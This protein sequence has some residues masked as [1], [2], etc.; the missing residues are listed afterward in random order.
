MYIYIIAFFMSSFLL[1]L[2]PRFNKNK[3]L[4]LFINLIALIIP[5]IL[6]GVRN[7]II[8]TDVKSYVIPMF[9][10]AT[11]SKN[12]YM[13]MNMKWFSIWT[14]WEIKQIEFGFS[15]L[16]YIVCKLTGNLQWLLFCIQLLTIIPIYLGLKKF[17]DLKSDI[18]FAILVY[19]LLFY[20]LSL[21]LMR[22]F[23]SIGI[24]FFGT[25]CLINDRNGKMKFWLALFVFKG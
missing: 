23:I 17:K 12:F 3:I 6:A 11:N 5:C 1:K 20:N 7:S 22:Q 14:Y 21:N 19:F 9:K 10:C 8:G 2:A 18:W 4:Q 25:S 16:V 24:I 13:Y 15:L